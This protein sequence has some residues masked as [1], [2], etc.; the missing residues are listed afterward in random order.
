MSVSICSTWSMSSMAATPTS[1]AHVTAIAVVRGESGSE[2][3]ERHDAVLDGTGDE[4]R[5]GRCGTAD[6][7][8]LG[9]DAGE[10]GVHGAQRDVELLGDR[11]LG[12]DEH[13]GAQ[14][15][16]LASG[17]VRLR[18]AARGLRAVVGDGGTG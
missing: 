13:P 8:V 18:A 5:L 4:R 6:L 15:L 9:A 1:I 11:G 2:L 17:E 14:H 3:V 10:M 12:V 16:D 7:G